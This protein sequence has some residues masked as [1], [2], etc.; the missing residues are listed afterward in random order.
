[1][2][3]GGVEVS[4]AAVAAEAVCGGTLLLLLLVLLLLVG[5]VLDTTL[6]ASL[7][8]VDGAT[9]PGDCCE[10]GEAK[11]VEESAQI[12]DRRLAQKYARRRDNK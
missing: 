4:E 9:A 6:A 11:H 10:F 8:V 2:A 3:F 1:M 7:E 5:A 12:C